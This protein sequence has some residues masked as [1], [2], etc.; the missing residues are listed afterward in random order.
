MKAMSYGGTVPVQ[1]CKSCVVYDAQS[2]RIE[3]THHAIVLKGGRDIPDDEIA[4]TALGMLR[5]R[6]VDA[7]KLKVLHT[8]P[9]ALEAGTVYAVDVAKRVLVEKRKRTAGR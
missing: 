6:G 7:A 2:G 1:S 8:S 3:H 9:D 4:A 5:E